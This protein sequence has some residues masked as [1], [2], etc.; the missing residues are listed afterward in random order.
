MNHTIPTTAYEVVTPEMAERYLKT[1][2]TNNRNV[3]MDWVNTLAD[4][5]NNGNWQISHQGIAFDSNGVLLDGQHRLLAIVKAKKAVTMQVTRGLSK[6]TF[7]SI[8]AGI[9]RRNGDHFKFAGVP[10]A[11]AV[12]AIICRYLKAKDTKVVSLSLAGN[13]SDVSVAIDTYYQDEGYWQDVC[14]FAS[15][16]HA[17]NPRLM[18]KTD[19]GFLVAHLE[20]M[21]G[22]TSEHV[23]SFV[24]QI[25]GENTQFEMMRSLRE[26]LYKLTTNPMLKIDALHKTQYIRKAWDVYK[27]YNKCANMRRFT[28]SESADGIKAF[29]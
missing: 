24:E 2:Y 14:R 12:A 11:T 15:K 7:K 3:R 27:N 21:L 9:G 23:R 4:I 16:I 20:R 6:N 13:K 26:Q 25:Y 5:I 22:Y 29:S 19:I 8:D 18:N 17:R 10:N 28:Y 1:N